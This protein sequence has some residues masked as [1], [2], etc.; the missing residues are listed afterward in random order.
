MGGVSGYGLLLVGVAIWAECTG[1]N[2]RARH[3]SHGV[4]RMVRDMNEVLEMMVR[5]L[6]KK[7]D[8]RL[9]A[10]GKRK[11]AE[12]ASGDG[13]KSKKSRTDKENLK[14]QETA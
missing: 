3:V 6:E 11:A 13:R 7:R 2:P 9:L 10:G 4:M 1:K 12:V 8:D 14:G 5:Y